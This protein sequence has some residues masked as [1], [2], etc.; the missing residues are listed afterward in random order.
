M[1]SNSRLERTA[2]HDGIVAALA[3]DDQQAARGEMSWVGNDDWKPVAV[4][5]VRLRKLTGEP[6]IR[7]MVGD[8]AILVSG[9]ARDVVALVFIKGHPIVK[10]VVRM[11]RQLLKRAHKSRPATAA[12]SPNPAPSPTAPNLSSPPTPSTPPDPSKTP[13]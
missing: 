3:I 13:L 12:S 1:L 5:A 7:V 10:S 8:H 6:S 9:D 11:T 2:A 4:E